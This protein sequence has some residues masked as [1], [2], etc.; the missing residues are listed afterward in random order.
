[1][2]ERQGVEPCHA[3]KEHGFSFQDCCL[4]LSTALRKILADAGRLELPHPCG[5]RFSKPLRLP[6]RHAS[7]FQL[8]N[9]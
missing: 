7:V 8:V 6:F 9:R 3:H 4:P 1:M 5:R 2:A